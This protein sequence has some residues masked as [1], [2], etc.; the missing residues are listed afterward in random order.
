MSGSLDGFRQQPLVRG[1]DSAYSS[2][3]YFPAFGD[4]MTEK[5]S[6]F[7]IYI[8]YLFRAELTHS[9]APNTEPF[10]TWHNI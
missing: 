7:E 10:G 2:G 5:F 1:A 3:Q 4:K 9:L 6:I 8:G